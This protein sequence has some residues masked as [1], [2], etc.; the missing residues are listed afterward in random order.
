MPEETIESFHWERTRDTLLGLPERRLLVPDDRRRAFV[1]RGISVAPPLVFPIGESVTDV[2]SYLE[3]LPEAPTLH[4]VILL[5]AG[6]ASL[7]LFRR[8][9]EVVTKSIKKYVVRGR[10]KA[11]PS[12]LSSKGKSRYG[13]R[14]RLQNARRLLLEVN[15]RLG[16]WFAEHG[17]PDHVYYNA[18]VRLWPDLF[19]AKVRPPFGKDEATIRIP[20]DLPVP[21][22]EVLLRTYRRMSY[23]RIRTGRLPESGTRGE[24][25]R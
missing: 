17:R 12:Y 18:P 7:G 10:G 9:E 15:E 11:Q 21:T 23:G 4:V 16:E 6:A 8:G 19:Q 5:Q 22:T 1:A 24:S 20:L 13:S 14:L 3:A 25:D 2:D